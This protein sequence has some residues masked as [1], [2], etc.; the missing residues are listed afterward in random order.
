M[1]AKE[2]GPECVWHR[3]PAGLRWEEQGAVLREAKPKGGLIQA[4]KD[5]SGPIAGPLL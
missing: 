4:T 3:V 5:N 2:E 1:Q